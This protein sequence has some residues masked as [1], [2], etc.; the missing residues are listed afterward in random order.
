MKEFMISKIWNLFFWMIALAVSSFCAWLSVDSI[1]PTYVEL[2]MNAKMQNSGSVKIFYLGETDTIWSEQKS[3]DSHQ[4]FPGK[5]SSITFKIPVKKLKTFRLDFQHT[6]AGINTLENIEVSG[7]QK[8][9]LQDLKISGCFD[10]NNI[11]RKENQLT[12]YAGAIDPQL[13]FET[14]ETIRGKRNFDLFLAGIVFSLCMMLFGGAWIGIR[15]IRNKERDWLDLV[16]VSAIFL[17]LCIPAMKINKAAVSVKEN[18]TLAQFPKIL[19]QR[20]W[21]NTLF[22]QQFDSYFNDRFLGR[23]TLLD[24]YQ[25]LHTTINLFARNY[26]VSPAVVEGKNGWFFFRLDHSIRNYQNLDTFTEQELK[27]NLQHLKAMNDW[28]KKNNIKFYYYIAPDK[29]KIYGEYMTFV[30]KVYP[31]SQSRANQWVNYIRKNSDITVLYP[32]EELK[33]EKLQGLLYYKSD[34]HWNKLGSYYGYLALMKEIKKDFPDLK[35]FRMTGQYEET[36]RYGDLY[37]FLPHVI[38]ED[39]N[40]YQCP[41]LPSKF[42]KKLH[43]VQRYY[44]TNPDGKRSVFVMRD[45]FGSDLIPYLYYTM[46]R[47]TSSWQ[48]ALKPEDLK[49]LQ[50]T[51]TDMVILIHVERHLPKVIKELQTQSVFSNTRSK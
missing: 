31:D 16:S 20:G 23:N 47:V 5:G 27:D 40:I 9:K 18:R 35:E 34:S 28:C 15:I 4:I 10:V 44:N 38:G 32:V 14:P 42:R 43:S 7:K 22:G 13:I 11:Q 3:L 37:L 29:H 12:M 30:P 26:A 17:L 41:D 36:G 33:K 2:T 19:T 21:I 46:N 49:E 1:T 48:F 25:I 51:R 24:G 8:C 45:S 39:K 6:A 50:N